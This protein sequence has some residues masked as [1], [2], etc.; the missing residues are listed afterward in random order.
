MPLPNNVVAEFTGT[1]GTEYYIYQL[2]DNIEASQSITN[3]EA[4]YG[5]LLNSN[6]LTGTF[7]EKEYPSIDF[8]ASTIYTLTT[9]QQA[10]Y[11]THPNNI[12]Y[13]GQNLGSL[14]F[15]IVTDSK[16]NTGDYNFLY[17]TEYNDINLGFYLNDG[18]AVGFIYNVNITG[19]SNIDHIKFQN[20]PT[21]DAETETNFNNYTP[22]VNGV[23]YA[24]IF[25]S[26]ANSYEF[27]KNF[28][29]KLSDSF[30]TIGSDGFHYKNT[31]LII[32]EKNRSVSNYQSQEIIC[33]PENTPITTDQGIVAIQDLEKDS[34]TIN[35][36]KVLGVVSH[37]PKSPIDMVLFKQHS[38]GYNMPNK[39]TLM[40]RNHQV[41]YNNVPRE[42]IAYT[43]NAFKLNKTILKGFPNNPKPQL[44]RYNKEVYNV[45]LEDGH[46]MKVNNLLVETLHPSNR[47]Y[48]SKLNN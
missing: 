26:N 40:T 7:P 24:D 5:I 27:I 13:D 31:S 38:L 17:D 15:S 28:N 12:S 37:K 1:S 23:T 2:P 45:M 42:A 34:Y 48:K 35:R 14:L 3:M 16:N 18:R 33:F 21:V 11:V 44:T 19:I 6:Y 43:T 36:N 9:E 29:I 20:N 4:N 39:D 41:Y 8:S 32:V 46:K 30:S 25:S 22:S 47:L 10:P